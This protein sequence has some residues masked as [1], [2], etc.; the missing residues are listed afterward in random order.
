MPLAGH[1]HRPFSSVG[2]LRSVK[3]NVE[4]DDLKWLQDE[5]SD[6][7]LLHDLGGYGSRSQGMCGTGVGLGADDLERS[8]DAKFK[9][10]ISFRVIRED[11][12]RYLFRGFREVLAAGRP[13]F[14]VEV[15][16]TVHLNGFVQLKPRGDSVSL[17]V[18][19][20]VAQSA[21]LRQVLSSNARCLNFLLREVGSR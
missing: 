11:Q 17:E 3:L 1:N 13:V 9:L 7:L 14:D 15:L 20:D 12:L 6:W 16:I 8:V 5:V 18:K 19:S 2:W 10:H 21:L 4:F